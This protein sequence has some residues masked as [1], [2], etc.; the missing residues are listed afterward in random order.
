MQA[1]VAVSLAPPP[2]RAVRRSAVQSTTTRGEP[3]SARRH[4]GVAGA[5]A[6]PVR[7]VRAASRADR[8]APPSARR[9][10]ARAAFMTR[11]S[12]FTATFISL[13]DFPDGKESTPARPRPCVYA[14]LREQDARWWGATEHASSSARANSTSSSQGCRTKSASRPPRPAAAAPLPSIATHVTS[15]L[16]HTG[17][18]MPRSASR[19]GRP[20]PRSRGR[21]CAAAADHDRRP[22]Q[23]VVARWFIGKERKAWR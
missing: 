23:V 9:P 10:P 22:R 1:R 13:L 19:S 15:P 3:S 16:R 11:I 4:A 12:D 20:A 14:S 6:G 7:G 18:F 2:R 8:R 17:L 21:T 5:P